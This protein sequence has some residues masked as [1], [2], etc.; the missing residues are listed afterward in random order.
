M[1]VKQELELVSA[2]LKNT[3]DECNAALSIAEASNFKELPSCITVSNN[4]YHEQGYN[5][6]FGAGMEQGREIGYQDGYEA[7]KAESGEGAYETGFAA[8]YDQGMGEGL[9]V[10]RQNGIEDGKTEA[11]NAF[12]D[13]VQNNGERTEYRHSFGPIFDDNNFKPKYNLN[14]ARG[15]YMFAYSRIT[16]LPALLKRQGVTLDFSFA[17]TNSALNQA[18][19]ESN[20]TRLG[21][22][23][24]TG[25]GNCN[26][27]FYC[28]RKLVNIEKVIFS[29]T[30]THDNTKT[31]FNQCESLVDVAFEGV[32]KREM[33]LHWSTKLSRASIESLFAVLDTS[34]TGYTATFSKT[35]VEAAFTTDEWTAL[36]ATRSNW[37]IAKA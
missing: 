32:I 28:A 11:Y 17:T 5:S 24:L 16:D 22:V 21:V 36:C 25:Q 10:G 4:D 7:G 34:V 30:R 9:E 3:L 35:A 23:D 8:G 12:W 1:G 26:Y 15:E 20:I 27:I 6:G 31:M 29:S 18:F 37:T 19:Y 14:V 13:D 33:D 2:E